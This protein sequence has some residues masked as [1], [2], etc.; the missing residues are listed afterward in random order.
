MIIMGILGKIK[1]LFIS[2]PRPIYEMK[3]T[4]EQARRYIPRNVQKK[5]GQLQA[6]IANLTKENKNLKE[7]LGLLKKKER[8]ILNIRLTKRKR[9]LIL[10]EKRNRATIFFDLK[11]G[12][13]IKSALKSKPFKIGSK[14]LIYWRGIEFQDTDYGPRINFLASEKK[15]SKR[16]FRVRGVSLKK[17]PDVIHDPQSLVQNLREGRLLLDLTPEQTYIPKFEMRIESPEEERAPTLAANG[18]NPD[19]SNVKVIPDVKRMKEIDMRKIIHESP[20]AARIIASLYSQMNRMIG[21]KTE[22]EER[23]QEAI[24]GKIDAQSTA[25]VLARGLDRHRSLLDS[26]LDKLDTAYSKLGTAML[27]EQDMKLRQ[28]LAEAMVVRTQAAL[29][30]LAEKLEGRESRTAIEEAKREIE[31]DVQFVLDRLTAAGPGPSV[32]TAPP[33]PMKEKK[34]ER[35]I[36]RR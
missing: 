13:K 16:L 19:N 20:E 35:R 29:D 12:I 32:K 22:A 11:R 4:P 21:E 31:D 2:K 27:T 18:G 7:R 36:L 34:E 1:G 24:S 6:M 17:F 10:E 15:D 9:K 28:A 3:M 25:K 14:F 33:K 23:E 26:A 8:E 5:L 30:R